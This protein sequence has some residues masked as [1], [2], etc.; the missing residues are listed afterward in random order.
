MFIGA[1]VLLF[2]SVLIT[3]ST[4]L[5]VYNKITTY[6]DASHI[7]LVINDQEAH[8]NKYQLWIGVFLGLFSGIAQYLRFKEGN[9][10]TYQKKFLTHTGIAIAISLALTFLTTL[11][12]KVAAWQYLLLLFTGIFAVVTNV[13]YLLTFLKGNLKMAGS[14]VSHI[15]F[16]LMIV[17]VIASGTN[18]FHISKNEFAM[19]GMFSDKEQIKKNV[20]LIKGEPMF[21]SG[22][23]VNYERDT[24]IGNENG[25][26]TGEEFTLRPNI[27]YNNKS[28][29]AAANP[30]TK[31]YIAEDIFAC[32]AGIPA[33]HQGPAEAKAAEDSLQYEAYKGLVGDTIFTKDHYVIIQAIN[34][35][36]THPDYLPQKGDIA[37]GIKAAVRRLDFD[38]TWYAEPVML[39]RGI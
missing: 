37:V 39:L 36:A 23:M 20:L 33:H 10:G 31:R 16:G 34:Q 5:P 6:F 15:G 19:Q 38:S 8:H 35:Q 32:V 14:A 13:D 4:S 27:I 3:V 24:M 12:I 7:P 25:A 11:W 21:M 26:S 18:Q 2:S 29:F 1:L 22:Y 28:E 30:Y 17:G 9:F